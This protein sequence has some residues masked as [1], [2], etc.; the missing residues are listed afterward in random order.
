MRIELIISTFQY[1]HRELVWCAC[2]S[3]VFCRLNFMFVQRERRRWT[4]GHRS[5]ANYSE[6][7]S[8]QRFRFYFS[9]H[10][11]FFRLSRRVNHFDAHPL[12]CTEFTGVLASCTTNRCFPCI[13]QRR[14]WSMHKRSKHQREKGVFHSVSSFFRVHRMEVC[15]VGGVCVCTLS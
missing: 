12:L 5:T 6:L 9:Q 2:S 15:A 1:L 7:L 4:N 10:F 3:V 14:L 11:F 8:S 13:Q